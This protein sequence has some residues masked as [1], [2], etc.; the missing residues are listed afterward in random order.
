MIF[1][2]HFQ[3]K[4]TMSLRFL[5][6]VDNLKL[7]TINDMKKM[8][9]S[10]GSY[11]NF[12]HKKDYMKRI[13]L[14]KDVINFPW[15]K[16]QR[17]ALEE[18]LKFE[19]DKYVIHAV[20]GAGKTTLLLGMLVMGVF[21]I[22]FKPEEVMFISFNISIKNEIKRKLKKYGIANKISVRTFDSIIYEICKVGKYPYI[23]LPN[24]EGKR[25]FVYEKTFEKDF[26]FIPSYQPKVIFIDE[27]QD[28]ERQMLDILYRFYPKSKFIFAGDIFQSIQKEPRESILWHYMMLEDKPDI[29]KIYMYDTPRVPV[30][31]LSRLQTSLSMYYPEFHDK[32]DNWTS[33]NTI[34]KA[35][36]IWKRLHS[37]THIFKD[38]K[39]YLEHPDHTPD[40]TMILTF[41]SAI[42]VRGNMGDIAR[43]RRFMSE[44][45]FKVNTNHKKQEEDAYFLTTA[46][47][48]K[49]LERDYV[50]IFLTFPLERAFVSLSDDVVV[51]LITVALTRA[52]KQVVMYVP[53]YEDKYSKV[54]SL[55]ETCPIPNKKRIREG[56]IM[57]EFGFQ[58]YVDI[59][60]CVTELIRGGVIKYDTRILFRENTKVFNFQKLFDEAINCKILPIITEEEKAF[61]GVLIE[62][63]ITSTWK[64]YWPDNPAH[65]IKDNPMFSHIINRLSKSEKKYLGFRKSKAFNN[66]N[67]FEGIYLFSQLVVALSNKLF[68]RLSDSLYKNLSIYWSYLRPKC[69]LIKPNTEN[70]LVIQTPMKMPWVTGIADAVSSNDKEI[71]LYEIK[72]SK[73][74]EWKD[75]ALL[76]VMC[77]ALMSGKSWSRLHLIN[78]FRNEK[79]S[80]YFDT[81]KILTLR[82]ELLKDILVYNI[83]SM[84]AKMYPIVRNDGSKPRLSVKNTLFLD[85]RKNDS[86]EVTQV[87]IINM[88]SPI[89]CEVI[90]NKYSNNSKD[91]ERDM[92]RVEKFRS[93]STTENILE[94][95]GVILNNE[96]NK[97]KVIW[98]FE[99]YEELKDIPGNINSVSKMYELENE[100]CINDYLKYTKNTELHYSINFEESL[101][102]NIFLMSFMFFNNIFF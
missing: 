98:S 64:G 31:I 77:Y 55:F 76:Q 65:N 13:Q 26:D 49:G 42:T 36:I 95:V 29:Y 32:I 35:D 60:H 16:D 20:F 41:S 12:K 100:D 72:A 96:V 10:V 87:S 33:S 53:S 56:K 25:K 37:Y 61:V 51:N 83:N 101:S 21:K 47:S 50:I 8:L 78:P 22:L 52:K 99:N 75:N 24:F 66:I 81:K 3:Q 73:D 48:S 84:M 71:E 45:N 7:L 5:W 43:V 11:S 6:N 58:D 80:Y 39:E 97:D 46:N 17:E 89:K 4:M 2:C 85:L 1:Y 27:V 92:T 91:R 59:E 14:Y 40:K 38:L 23:D 69:N 54:L 68:I 15:R 79:V 102:R 93:E 28:L 86:G 19:H 67:Q 34:S 63:L 70:K 82:G 88:L 94:E 9:K 18:F 30:N 57:K 62:N 74:R 90:Y 44:N